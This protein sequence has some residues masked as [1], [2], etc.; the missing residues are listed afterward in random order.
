MNE[1]KSISFFDILHVIKKNIWLVLGVTLVVTVVGT[2]L[3]YFVYN[4]SKETYS[5]NFEI[6][7]D[8]IVDG[9]YPD[10]TI[11]R[12]EDL[13]SLDALK[14]VVNSNED[15]K[16][17]DYKD[18]LEKNKITITDYVD[19]NSKTDSKKVEASNIKVITIYAKYFSDRIQASEFMKA[20]ANAPLEKANNLTGELRYDSNLKA[21]DLCESSYE[22]KVNFLKAQ[23]DYLIEQYN[24]LSD[25]FNTKYSVQSSTLG[26]DSGK[27]L[28][29]FQNDVLNTFTDETYSKLNNKIKS[30]YLTIDMDK[31]A[32]EAKKA[33]L[34]KQKTENEK[35]LEELTLKYQELVGF[36]N[37]ASS[38]IIAQQESSFQTEMATIVVTNA[39]IVN[40]IKDIDEKL[41]KFNG[42]GY[43]SVAEA[44]LAEELVEIRDSLEDR[45][46]LFAKVKELAMAKE[47]KAIFKTNM[48]NLEGGMNVWLELLI[49][50]LIGFVLILIIV[51]IK[52]LPKMM[53]EKNAVQETVEIKEPSEN[54]T[55]E[56]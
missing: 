4:K 16:S 13:I 29:D 11:F 30:N 8:A 33:S 31:S 14:E 5:Y 55:E 38:D 46:E 10:G 27:S 20:I 2:L 19:E 49:S 51:C 37:P 40:Q 24:L 52:D 22:N 1:D 18:M 50:L 17:I 43:N 44:E 23:R 12:Y 9:K 7:T 32:L 48:P 47:S 21:F 3:F 28:A 42:G 26:L 53:K 45:T 56:K 6:S 41:K 36:L 39:K 54:I 15:F 34:E 35:I 25:V